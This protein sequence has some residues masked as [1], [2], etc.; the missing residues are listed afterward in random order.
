MQTALKHEIELIGAPC[1]AGASSAGARGGPQAL[2]AAGLVP[3]LRALGRPVHDCGNLTGPLPQHGAAVAGYRHLDEVAAWNRSVQ[4]AVAASLTRQSLPLLLGGDHSL[5][6]GSLSAVA[7]HC[8]AQGRPLHVFWLDAHADCNSRRTSPSANLHGMPLACLCGVGPA[9]LT[10]LAG[11]RPPLQGRQV[12][13]V[14]VRSVDPGE[15]TLVQQL[16]LQV[17]DM[18][19]LRR[20]G[21]AHA[22]AAALAGIEPVA[23][24]H[25]SL[26]VDFLDPTLAPGTAT[27][28]GGGAT[29]EQANLCMELLA[30]TGRVASVDV[31]ELDPARD[32]RQR[33]ARHAV[34]LLSA[35]LAGK[36]PSP[37]A[38]SMDLGR[39]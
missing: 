14:G 3:A 1:D 29:L 19:T 33:T 6:I 28:V 4:A 15:A 8:H 38:A 21:V 9:A 26:D 5:S 27:A 7:A 11:Q 22:L 25:V 20:L 32:R 39:A 2:R 24:V 30:A 17:L 35:L 18:A 37:A 23:H 31:M 10:G 12:H 34:T 13:L 16:G 36:S